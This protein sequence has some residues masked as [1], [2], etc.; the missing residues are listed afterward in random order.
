MASTTTVNTKTPG[1]SVEVVL[2]DESAAYYRKQKVIIYK[3]DV[4]RLDL[5]PNGC[6]VVFNSDSRFDLTVDSVSDIDGVNPS[7][8]EE[9]YNLLNTIIE[10]NLV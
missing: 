6:R 2:S 5:M 4:L 3:R 7:T 8:N 9:L 10:D 1:K